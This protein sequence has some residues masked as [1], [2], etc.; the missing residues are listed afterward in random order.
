MSD[1][2]KPA[3]T[4]FIV[5]FIAAV[6]LGFVHAI[7]I[8]PIKSQKEKFRSET[9]R[10]ILP[11]GSEFKEDIAIPEGSSITNAF[12]AYKNDGSIIGYIVGS[13]S[14]GFNG[15]ISVLVGINTN[16]TLQAIKIT[17]HTETPGLGGNAT[18]AKFTDQYKGLSHKISL[19][20]F[21]PK[22]NEVQAI[23][24]ATITSNAVTLAVNNALE[25]FISNIGG[26]V[27]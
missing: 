8:E 11:S 4:L 15:T 1:I 22:S 2:I 23:T 26:D 9:M 19:T 25:F 3:L 21:S 13:D 24:S 17:E 27:Q 6:C 16:A 14:K 20:K 12:T 10:E 5:T 7:T 18:D